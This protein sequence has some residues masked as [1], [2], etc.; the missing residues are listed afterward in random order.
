VAKGLGES[1]DVFMVR[2]LG[3]TGHEELTMGAHGWVSL[4]ATYVIITAMVVSGNGGGPLG[5]GGSRRDVESHLVTLDDD[6]AW[7]QVDPAAV[8]FGDEGADGRYER[9]GI[10]GRGGMGEIHLARDRR[11]G[12]HVAMKVMRRGVGSGSGGRVRFMREVCVQ[13]QFEH[14]VVVPVYDV[15]RDETGLEFFTMKRVSGTTL[16]DVI[17]GLRDGTP[18]VTSEFTRHRLLAA[19]QRVCL[20]IECA[21][22]H[23]VVHRDLKPSNIMFGNYGEVYVL[24][25]GL[26]KFLDGEEER[27]SLPPPAQGDST[28]PRV[29]GTPGYMPPEQIESPGTVDLRADIYA[30]GAIL[31][32]ILALEPLHGEGGLDEVVKSTRQGADARPS[33]R[34]R[35]HDVDPELDAICVRATA[36][37]PEDRYA[38][39]R[40]LYDDLER[41][42][43]GHRDRRV[44]SELAAV[45]AAVAREAAEEAL[46]GGPSA[47]EAR[48]RALREAGR[49]LAL[50]PED[51]EVADTLTRLL[52]EPPV[53]L[54]PEAIEEVEGATFEEAKRFMRLVSFA[55]LGFLGFT[56]TILLSPVRSWAAFASVTVPVGLAVP[57]ALWLARAERTTK[58]LRAHGVAIFGL[59][60]LSIMATSGLYGP[61]MLTPAFALV[62]VVLV[63]TVAFLG[64]YRIFG[65]LFGSLAVL[66]PTLLEH[67]GV[68]PPSYVFEGGTMTIVPRVRDISSVAVTAKTVVDVVTLLVV[69]TIMWRFS[70]ELDDKRRQI[71]VTAWHLKQLLPERA[72]SPERAAG[73]PSVAP[74]A[75]GTC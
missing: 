49:A 22:T 42:L 55:L 39:A 4:V 53:E 27:A 34:A 50:R 74:P 71:Q 28:P 58:N 10:L 21:H 61:A 9:L 19:V 24:D 44:R 43:D 56:A 38:S 13:A 48:V 62:L 6:E 1:V 75:R 46:A 52:L 23:G 32:E 36:R 47:T 12:R 33:R 45:H 37:S 59:A 70:A 15:D 51:P 20:G 5:S 54:P 66:V 72:A 69:G 30:L 64:H 17:A 40:G 35:G 63:S 73:R 18:E 3:A 67:I 29:L 57:Y 7:A 11:I 41:Y 14:P 68:L 25:W 2:K 31:F 26:A 65:L 60:S 8:R 16:A